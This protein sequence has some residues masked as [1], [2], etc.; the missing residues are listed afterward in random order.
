MKVGLIDIDSKIPNL[1]LMK[2]SAYHKQ[3]GHQV[4]LTSPLFAN[5]NGYDLIIASKIFDYTPMPILP[6][7]T[8]IG[9]SGYDLKKKLADPVEHLY[10]DYGLFGCDYAIGYTSRG[11]NRRCPFCIVPKKE[12][13]FKI[14]CD[15]IREFWCGQ[16]HL[17]FLDNSMNTDEDHFCRILTQLMRMGIRVDFSQGLDIRHL[18]DIQALALSQLKTWGQTPFRFAWDLMSIEKQV[19]RG[20]GILGKAKLKSKS[21]FYV[22]I[23]FDTTPEEDLY[24]VE[25]LRG[26]G[27]EPFVMPFN[28]F[29]Q[30]QK[31]FTRWVNYKAIF[32][33]VKWGEYRA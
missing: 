30:Y 6:R 19:R 17:V 21:M 29:N 22:L 15:D 32:K 20:I 5:Q 24:R 2:L 23:G 31:D 16:N 10:P 27:V 28:K 7:H 8:Q 3:S 4:E 25:I 13:K 18:T 11:C 26:L 14:V 12:G 33:S 9:G 1:A